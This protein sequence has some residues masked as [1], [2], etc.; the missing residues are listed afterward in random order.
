MPINAQNKLAT[1]K[2]PYLLQHKDNPV[3][4]FPW[5]PEAFELAEKENKPIFLSIGYSTC[6]WCHVMEH[7]SF[8]DQEVAKHLNE[9]FIS[10]KVDRE[11]RPDIDQIY[12]DAVVALT[13]HG[14]WP[15]SVFLTPKLK[16]FFGGTYFKKD[17]FIS[18]LTAISDAWKNENKSLVDSSEKITA[19]L[20]ERMVHV[21]KREVNEETFKLAL[22]EHEKSYDI[23]YGGFGLAPKFPPSER[24]EL[25]LRIERR[26]DN[27]NALDMAVNTLE[28]MAR[29]GIYDQLGGGFHRYATDDKWLIPHFEKMLYDNALLSTAYLE[30]YQV[31]AN[32]MFAEVARETLNYVL[33][34]MTSLE[35]G[36]YSAEDAGEVER[37]GE[38]YVWSYDELKKLLTE[39]ELKR[40]CEIYSCSEFGNF[41]GTNILTLDKKSDWSAKNEP[42]VVSAQKKLLTA[43]TKRERPR[44]DD[45][46]LTAWNGLMITAMSK[47]YRVLADEA[48]LKA[49]RKAL[50]FIKKNL[51]VDG[52]LLRRYRDKD[53]RVNAFVDDYA[54]LIQALIEMY[55]SDFDKQ[56]IDWAEDLQLKQIELFWDKKD[57]G[58]FYSREDD[59][60]LIFRKKDFTDNAIP[61]ANA[62]SALNLLRLSGLTHNEIFK[63]HA[64]ELLSAMSGQVSRAPMAYAS[65]LIAFDYALD[66]SKEI[67][68]IAG[69][70]SDKTAH[71]STFLKQTFLPNVVYGLC[72]E[73]I[74][75]DQRLPLLKNKTLHN[76]L[77]TIYVCEFGNCSAPTNDF[78]KA[79][80]LIENLKK[81]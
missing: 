69:D 66:N 37:E 78:K 75:D 15:M 52:Y 57:K 8:E 68:I 76:D 6:Y 38:Y 59:K 18:L 62:I 1:E 29:G 28:H 10:I 70:A 81:Y 71:I 34:D 60:S 54:F 2:S 24:I 80:I 16:P 61:S 56:W 40:I 31:T 53:A 67:A 49:G 22:A 58:F 20:E 35:G 36:F 79:K 55:Q 26:S 21:S 74:S 43:R 51:T 32:E 33:R 46:I 41:E 64:D 4:W 14:G 19:F 13:G 72:T 65:S 44:K 11:E 39:K 77:T 23:R 3:N 30:A 50:N 73:N 7:E 5:G 45:K 48:Y 9:N 17:Q 12:M 47:G 63:T 25:L 27:K 42:I